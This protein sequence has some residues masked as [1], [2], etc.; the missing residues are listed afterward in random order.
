MQMSTS[1]FLWCTENASILL[2]STSVLSYSQKFF[3][4]GLQDEVRLI[5]NQRWGGENEIILSFQAKQLVCC[6][7]ICTCKT[8]MAGVDKR[9]LKCKIPKLKAL[10]V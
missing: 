9:K 1:C 8:E 6:Q 7:K 10:T 4:N 3:L 2:L 5:F